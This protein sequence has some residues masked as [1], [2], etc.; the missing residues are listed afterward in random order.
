VLNALNRQT[1]EE[2]GDLPETGGKLIWLF[3]VLSLPARVEKA[4]IAGADN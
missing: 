1:M 4:F 2:L 3:R